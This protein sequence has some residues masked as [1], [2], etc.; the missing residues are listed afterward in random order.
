MSPVLNLCRTKSRP[1]I[2]NAV[3][4]SQFGNVD[5]SSNCHQILARKMLVD[6][7]VVPC[8]LGMWPTMYGGSVVACIRSTWQFYAATGQQM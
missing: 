3:P 6:G 1:Q 5:K 4:R 7:M 2:L 8:R